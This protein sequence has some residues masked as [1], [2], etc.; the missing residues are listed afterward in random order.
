[1][2]SGLFWQ[3]VRFTSTC[4]IWTACKRRGYGAYT[5][6]GKLRV[7]HRLV[8]EE[9]RGP[10]PEGLTLDHLCRNRPCVNPDHL[11]PVTREE[12]VR[13]WGRTI[14]H[15]KR[16]HE[17]VAGSFRVEISKTGQARRFCKACVSRRRKA[18]RDARRVPMTP[19]QIHQRISA[20]ASEGWLT[21]RKKYGPN[22][23]SCAE[24]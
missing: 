9:M 24:Q 6:D 2:L 14:T 3:K 4:W 19:D 21:R 20:A 22:G 16:G 12:N 11:E 15:C 1:M 23:I 10:I 18:I 5:V 7:A 17:F 13:R 8:Y